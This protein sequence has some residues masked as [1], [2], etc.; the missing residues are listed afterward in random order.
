MKKLLILIL[1]LQ[2]YSTLSTAQDFTED[3]M[4]VLQIYENSEQ[5]S[6]KTKVKV[7]ERKDPKA[8][9][10]ETNSSFRRSGKNVLLEFEGI[11]RIVNH[12]ELLVI[13]KND[14]IVNYFPFSQSAE[15]EAKSAELADMNLS[16]EFKNLQ[17]N[18][19]DISFKELADGK[20][21]YSLKPKQGEFDQIE[22]FIDP[23]AF[24]DKIIYHY[25]LV[26]FPE[27]SRVVIDYQSF[28]NTNKISEEYFS[29]APYLE[30]KAEEFRLTKAFSNYEL[31]VY[32]N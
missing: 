20:K 24:L 10:Y 27:Y 17:D 28:D 30:Y 18:L 3:L 1:I 19:E 15:A 5:L 2:G 23:N 6:F 16:E 29:S 8:I 12:K 9:S 26:A 31:S 4:K 22:I 21:H 32:E 13:N 11:K 7:F 25:N 14:K